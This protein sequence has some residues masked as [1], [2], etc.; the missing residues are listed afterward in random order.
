MSTKAPDTAAQLLLE[1]LMI[2][3]MVN[4]TPVCPST[5]LLLTYDEG[6]L[7]GYGPAV[8]D[9]LAVQEV[10]VVELLLEEELLLLEDEVLEV[11]LVEGVAVSFLQELARGAIKATPSAAIPPF[12][13][14]LRS[15]VICFLLMI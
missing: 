3:L 2:I 12:K 11:L 14:A 13:N 10:L 1:L 9:A 5:I 8:S 6:D 15:I 4:A 7:V